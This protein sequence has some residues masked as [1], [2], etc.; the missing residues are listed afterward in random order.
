MTNVLVRKPEVFYGT[1]YVLCGIGCCVTS[2][3]FFNSAIVNFAI[4]KNKFSKEQLN[5]STVQ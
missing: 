1:G 4:L 3:F 5:L 2:G